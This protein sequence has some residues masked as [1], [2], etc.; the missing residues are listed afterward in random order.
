MTASDAP[1]QLAEL[2]ANN[3]PKIEMLRDL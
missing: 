1:S 2:S 3:W